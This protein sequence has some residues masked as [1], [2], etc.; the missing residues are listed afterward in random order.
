[1]SIITP[2]VSITTREKIIIAENVSKHYTSGRSELHT[3]RGVS[4]EIYKGS[5]TCIFG[6]SGSGKSTLLKQ[7]ALLDRPSSG[8]IWIGGMN[9]AELSEEI[10][11]KIRLNS[12]GFVFQD[13]ALIPEL[14]V[15]ENVI[16]PQVQ[17][18]GDIHQHTAEAMEL[19]ARVGLEKRAQYRP[20]ELSGG[21]QQR[22]AIARALIN[23]PS[24]VLADEPTANLDSSNSARVMRIL[25]SLSTDL[26]ITVVFISHEIEDRGY[27]DKVLNIRDGKLVE[28]S[29]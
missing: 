11:G 5:V 12:L 3:L 8:T 27:A 9:T 16:L 7:L 25:Q 24:I 26:H 22:V 2:S 18:G 1:M 14:T 20:H 13:N 10:R 17:I 15:I 23:K 19:L 21:E 4:F 6:K 28:G 29:A